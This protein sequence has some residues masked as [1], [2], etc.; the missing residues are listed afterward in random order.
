M[1]NFLEQIVQQKELEVEERK[2]QRSLSV[3]R[4]LTEN[5]S[6]ERSFLRS[7]KAPGVRIIAECKKKSPSKGELIHDYDPVTIASKYERGGAAA[8]SV[9]TDGP[10]FGGS[11]QDL[12]SVSQHLGIPVLRK[13]FIIDEYQIYEARHSGADSYLLMLSL[14]DVAKLQYFIEIG[15]DL[16]MEALVECHSAEELDEALH[17]DAQIIG[18]NN[19]D[20]RSLQVNPNQCGDLFK[21]FSKDLKDRVVVF[22]S[23]VHNATMINQSVS[24]GIKVFLIGE[25]LMKSADPETTLKELISPKR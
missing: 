22:E 3:L 20:L 2:K 18:I 23:G 24:Q 14:L 10:G 25:M 21:K 1:T 17:T 8:V 9:L 13:D 5:Q 12:Q 15:R 6:S 11:I 19:R 7:L 16:G 4:S